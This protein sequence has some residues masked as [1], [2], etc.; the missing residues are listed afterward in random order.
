LY[1]LRSGPESFFAFKRT[2]GSSATLIQ[3]WT[4]GAPRVPDERRALDPPVVPDAVVAEIVGLVEDERAGVEPALRLEAGDRFVPVRLPVGLDQLPEDLLHVRFLVGRHLADREAGELAVLA[5]E[6]DLG[7]VGRLGEERQLLLLAVEHLEEVVRGDGLVPEDVVGM[8]RLLVVAARGV[9][10]EDGA[11]EGDVLHRVSIAADRA[12]AARE[13]ELELALA[14]LAEEGDALGDAP[15]AEVVLHLAVEALDPVGV[16]DSLEDLADHLLLG[17]G[18]EVAL[19]RGLRDP[20]V[21]RE[22]AAEEAAR[23]LLVL[24][25]ERHFLLLRVGEGVVE[26]LHDR[27]GRVDRDP[28]PGERGRGERRGRGLKKPAAIQHGSSPRIQ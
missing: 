18:E 16:D 12:V 23:L 24:P 20:P 4:C 25:R 2:V 13:D 1:Y 9:S 6:R 15:A 11:A 22:V 14:G 7:L 21:V 3:T 27:L 17:G 10:V 19:D 5:A 28:G 26:R 8:V